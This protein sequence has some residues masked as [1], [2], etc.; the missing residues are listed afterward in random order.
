MGRGKKVSVRV[1]NVR[2]GVG[3]EG[4]RE[5]VEEGIILRLLDGNGRTRL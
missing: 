4:G 5:R 1:D 2:N 3:R